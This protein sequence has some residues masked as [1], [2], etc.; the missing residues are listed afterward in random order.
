[1]LDFKTLSCLL[2]IVAGGSALCSQ[3]QQPAEQ[4][5]QGN[6]V[7]AP[8]TEENGQETSVAVTPV[9]EVPTPVVIPPPANPI[10]EIAICLDTSGSMEGL[11]DA[12]RQKIWAIVNEF[13]F[14]EPQPVLRVALLTYGNDGHSAENGWVQ[15]K[16]GLTE[17]LD[18]V[19]KL[20]F[21]QVTN[22]GTELVGRVVSAATKRLPWST[23]PDALKLIVVAGNES[24]DQDTTVRFADA[25]KAAISSDIM[26]NAIFCGALNHVDAAGW[27][28]V[29]QLADGQF[30]A[31]D[32]NQGTLVMATPMDTQLASLSADL[33]LTYLAF[34]ERGDWY[35]SNQIAQDNNATLLNGEAAA[36]RA[37]C[38]AN[39]LYNCASWDL[40]DA[41]KGPD[42]DLTKIETKALPVVMQTMSPE[43]Q[44]LH[45]E[46]KGKER[47]AIQ[48]KI[49]AL[50][51]ERQKFIDAELQKQN[52]DNSKSF[53]NA[54]TMALRSQAE[55][56]GY[57]FPT[58]EA[59]A[60]AVTPES[61][62]TPAAPVEQAPPATPG[63]QG[64]PG[65]H[66][67]AVNHGNSANHGDSA[68]HGNSA[69]QKAKLRV[70]GKNEILEGC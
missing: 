33:N 26:V 21:E 14:A 2:S 31:I 63:V 55:A 24:A 59:P 11:I 61:G 38:K 66:G 70:V 32:H 58:K 51:A 35:G 39:G 6:G 57:R 19:S 69:N 52:L 36:T 64:T 9:V 29:A 50:A 68:N 54:F 34:G 13:V 40:V 67:S 53:D 16:V 45:I 62:A 10:V 17:D 65:N 42:F 41:M 25:S 20:L 49:N 8:Q 48:S 5:L 3:A 22:G 4:S 1:M 60:E 37:F 43:Q 46:T 47:A 15:Q 30:A 27:R 18:M 23:H 28:Q 12:A 56:K 7:P 44:I